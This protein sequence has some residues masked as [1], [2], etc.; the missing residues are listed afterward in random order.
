[1]RRR[2]CSRARSLAC[3]LVEDYGH[4][5][6][7]EC[8]HVGAVSFDAILKRT[9]AKY[10]LGLTAT[11]IR[12]DGQ[13][14][15]IFMQCGP[16]R[17]TAATPAGA[18][19]DLEVVPRACHARIDLPPD[20]GIQDV[21]RHLANDQARTEAIAAEVRNAS[22]QGRK[23][24]VLT[25]RIEHLDAIEARVLLSTG[26]LVGEGFDHPPLDTLVLAMPVSWKGTLQQYAGRLHWEHASK[27]DVRI[28]DFVDTGHPALLRMW[29]KRQRGYRAMG[30]RIEAEAASYENL[31]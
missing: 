26:K 6:V 3:R 16:I 4:V 24:L 23:V 20:A 14:P 13:Q 11:P 31:L 7:D 25:E 22:A 21:F 2:S 17:H 1:M 18:P 10:V 8:H 27:T 15:I 19:H 5:I 28:I 30:Y 29:D 9:K 12:R